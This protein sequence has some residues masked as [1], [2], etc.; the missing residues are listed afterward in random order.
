MPNI[1]SKGWAAIGF[2]AL[3]LIVFLVRAAIPALRLD[4]TT[5]GIV[6]DL[7]RGAVL[8]AAAFYFAGNA[9]KPKE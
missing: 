5:N 1:D 2:T 8:L 6:T 7:E 3:F 4:A 9:S